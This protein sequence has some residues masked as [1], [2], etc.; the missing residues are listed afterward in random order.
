MAESYS[1]AFEIDAPAIGAFSATGSR[2][3][4]ARHGGDGRANVAWLAWTPSGSD[5][6]SW[7]ESYGLFAAGPAL[8]EG[9]GLRIA[10][11]L[12]A[13]QDRSVYPFSGG[14]F[15]AREQTPN[16]PLGHYDV[17]NESPGAMAFGLIQTATLNGAQRCSPLNAVV[18]APQLSADFIALTSVSIWVQRD[19]ESASIV[20]VPATAAVISFSADRRAGCR[21]DPKSAAFVCTL[22]PGPGEP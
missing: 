13:A 9:S 17:R 10:A 20:R 6:V 21:Y 3:V 2:I 16:V 8:R 22:I 15:G 5:T 14:A 1:I 12:D 7:G 11:T 4:I 18:V 19:T